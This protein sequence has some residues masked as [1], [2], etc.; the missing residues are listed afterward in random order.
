MK[1]RFLQLVFAGLFTLSVATAGT[2]LVFVWSQ[3]A[4]AASCPG[5]GANGECLGSTCHCVFDGGTAF[6]CDPPLPTD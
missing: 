2:G 4:F 3:P 6:H 5:C 1:K